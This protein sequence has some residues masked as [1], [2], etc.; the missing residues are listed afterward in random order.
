M[1]QFLDTYINA[2]REVGLLRSEIFYDKADSYSV[3]S[4]GSSI[5]LD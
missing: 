3:S 5:T 1:C 4:Q 2:L